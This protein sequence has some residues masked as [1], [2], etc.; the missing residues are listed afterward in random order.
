MK[1][2]I[3]DGPNLNL[4]GKRE[5]HVYGKQTLAEI[6]HQLASLAKEKGV[7]VA[8]FQS[9]AEGEL[10]DKMQRSFNEV[11]A[12]IINPAALTH[13]S[14][15][16][17]DCIRACPKPVIEVHL[18]NIYGREPERQKSFVSPHVRGVIAGFGGYS[19]ILGLYAAIEL[20]ENDHS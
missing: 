10:I 2:L 4:L 14:L 7:E 15:A 3:L 1:L 5:P 11:D 13:T 17:A 16:L 8:F 12:F 19:Y 6:H 9:N 18:S 20:L